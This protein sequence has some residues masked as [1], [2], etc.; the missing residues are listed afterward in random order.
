MKLA[1]WLKSNDLSPEEFGA[2][3]ENCEND[4]QRKVAAKRVRRYCLPRENAESRIPR[5]D[6]MARIV[7]ATAGAV[8]AN[9]FY[10]I[11][12]QPEAERSAA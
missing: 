3:I 6:T 5:T 7:E 9:D 8:T 4:D 1:D 11:E 2:K 12:T 10:G